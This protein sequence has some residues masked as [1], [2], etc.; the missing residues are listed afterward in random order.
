MFRPQIHGEPRHPQLLLAGGVELRELGDGR[1]LPQQPQP[2]ETPL[3]D[4]AGRP[5]QLGRPA[6]LVLDLLDEVADLF[7]GAFRLL[8]LNADQRIGVLAIGK[9]DL[10]ETIAEQS[11]ANDRKKQADILP[12]Q[13]PADLAPAGLFDD[14]R[15]DGRSAIAHRLC[16]SRCATHQSYLNRA[17]LLRCERRHRTQVWLRASNAPAPPVSTQSSRTCQIK[18]ARSSST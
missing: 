2:I 4:G 8:T 12:E 14:R 11:Y 6:H 13:R 3:L 10:E 18:A 16:S 7:G 1:H 5:R 15:E 17:W 9:D